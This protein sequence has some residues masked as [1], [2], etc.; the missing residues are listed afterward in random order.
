[1][2][3]N[4]TTARAT[5]AC[6]SAL[7][8]GLLSPSAFAGSM[9]FA[10]ERLVQDPSCRTSG[11]AAIP[12][13]GPAGGYQVC[14][15]DNDSF[16][17]LVNQ[18]ALALAPNAMYPARTTG[19]GGFDIQFQ[20]TFTGI[21]SNADYFRKG[22]RGPTDAQTGAAAKENTSVPSF[23][24]LYSLRI[25]K[26]FGFGFEVGSEFGFLADTNIINGGVDL[27]IALLEG[28]RDS[29]PGYLPDLA[30]AGSVRTIT[31]T[32]QV[33]I[34]VAGASAVLSKPITIA[35]S[36]QLTPLV[37]FQYLWIFGDAGVVDLTPAT[38]PQAT[39]GFVGADQPGTPGSS[40][41]DGGP[42][43]SKGDVTDFNNNTVFEKV[44][45]DRQRLF[46]GATYRYEIITFGVQGSLDV[47]PIDRGQNTDLEK[48]QLKG[49]PGQTQISV[50]LGGS[51]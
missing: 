42:V 51:F 17:R 30:V 46:F 47:M 31:G 5:F 22:T 9:D 40:K 41:N 11:G 48:Q 3:T 27:R 25:R 8:L 13:T 32:P 39:C 14:E 20:G 50:Q 26:G 44:R 29:V 33:Q 12:D 38:D 43:C 2:L 37:G 34:T 19:Y 28:F 36:G 15:P 21:D 18:Y 49:V 23:L 1:M 24:Q 4:R 7:A 10:L 6:A 16:A 45:L 35:S